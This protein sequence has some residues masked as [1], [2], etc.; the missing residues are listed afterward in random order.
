M[1]FLLALSFS[2]SLASEGEQPYDGP[3]LTFTQLETI[4]SEQGVVKFKMRTA[5][6]LHY[7]NGDRRYPEGAQIVFYE[8]DKSISVAARANSVYYFAE[9]D[10]YEFRGDVEIKSL[11]KK[12]QL[13]TEELHLIPSTE[14]FYTDK[15][16]RIETKEEVLT[17]E[18]MT[19]KQDL[20]YYS[21]TKPQ[22]VLSVKTIK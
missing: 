21:V 3:I 7:E 10:V 13:N 8:T 11:S 1:V 4:Y 12:V 20:S 9:K 5:K 2:N 19:A 14:T 17:G 15:F 6:A 22:G 16:I 18:G